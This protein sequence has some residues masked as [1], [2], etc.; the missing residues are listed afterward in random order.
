MAKMGRP[1]VDFNWE[2]LEAL[3]QRNMKLI[4][5]CEIMQTSDSTILRRIKDKY[6]VTFEE[7]RDKKM[8]RTRLKLVEKALE[9]ADKNNVTMLIFCLKNLC[10]WVDKKEDEVINK[11]KPFLIEYSDGGKEVLGTSEIVVNQ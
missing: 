2:R 10:G 6:K 11:L 8:A 4:D 3:C 5:C 7:Y 9:L 1:P